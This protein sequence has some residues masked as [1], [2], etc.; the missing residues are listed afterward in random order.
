MFPWWSSPGLYSD[1]KCIARLDSVLDHVRGAYY[2]KSISET[3]NMF[4][5]EEQLLQS[6]TFTVISV[7]SASDK[8]FL[9]GLR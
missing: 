7:V 3:E 9:Q 2:C 6:L 5:F 8:E 4:V 1:W